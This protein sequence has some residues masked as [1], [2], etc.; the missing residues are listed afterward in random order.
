[1]WADELTHDRFWCP[2]DVGV[3][4]FAHRY[5]ERPPRRGG[6]PGRFQEGNYLN[7]AASLGAPFGAVLTNADAPFCIQAVLELNF[8]MG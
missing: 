7:M 1:M 6:V 5:R 2:I 3:E 4:L 8:A